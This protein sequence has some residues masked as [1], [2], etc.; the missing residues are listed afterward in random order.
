[1][2]VTFANAAK[3]KLKSLFFIFYKVYL[4]SVSKYNLEKFFSMQVTVC[5]WVTIDYSLV[6]N[7][8]LQI[9][10]RRHIALNTA[11]RLC[12]EFWFT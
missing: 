4:L 11:K 1:M 2:C 8:F 7:F 9:N 12:I 3:T 6:Y 10:D 5:Y